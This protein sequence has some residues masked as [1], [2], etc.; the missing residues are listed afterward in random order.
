MFK[1]MD[2]E[3]SINIGDDGISQQP[4]CAFRRIENGI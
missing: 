3:R 4:K 1:Y 2:S